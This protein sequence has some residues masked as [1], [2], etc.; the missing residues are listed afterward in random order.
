MPRIKVTIDPK[1][2]KPVELVPNYKVK[3][4]R[5][6]P[7]TGKIICGKK[8][9]ANHLVRLRKAQYKKRAVKRLQ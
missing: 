3:E 4:A 7:F 1:T 8:A 6:C 2:K 9:Y 5:K